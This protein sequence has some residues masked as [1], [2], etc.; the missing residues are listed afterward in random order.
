MANNSGMIMA[1]AG[2]T[3]LR[4]R[5]TAYRE[6]A[7]L[8]MLEL[9]READASFANLECCLQEGEDWPAYVAGTGRGATYMAANRSMVDDLKWMG[10]KMVYAANNHSADFDPGGVLTT[11]KYLMAGELPYAGLGASLTEATAPG[12]LETAHG[13]VA[14]ISLSDWGPRG[15]MDLSFQM[16]SHMMP[17][18]Q[19]PEFKSRPGVNLLRY[20][21]VITVDSATMDALRRASKELR[22]E[23]AKASRRSGIGKAVAFVG[24]TLL[25][26]EQDTDIVFHFMGKKFVLGDHFDISTEP[27]QEDL[28]RNYRWI[29][30][31]RRQA[32]FVVVAL[33][34]QGVR[35]V[36]DEEYTKIFAK[37]SIDA[38]A[39]VYLN[40]GAR[41]G[42]VE[43]Y[44]GKT[45]LYGV[46]NFY[47]QQDQVTAVPH[48][49]LLRWGMSTDTTAGEFLAKREMGEGKAGR[50]SAIHQVVYDENRE[51][52]EVRIYPLEYI[53][54]SRSQ[55]RRPMLAK[56]GSKI[57]D[58]VLKEA[59]ER[60]KPY[61]T[62][63]EIRDG[64][65]IARPK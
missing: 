34:D 6:E 60:S 38:G 12:Y 36:F 2:N 7:F 8:R 52:K 51:V 25:G 17:A 22:W 57:S 24:P 19:G 20:D 49:M 64:V 62:D 48:E 10:I 56:P 50:H 53:D 65:G 29:R 46:P 37:G 32:D 26:G 61:G 1:F 14:L 4:H 9:L 18:D 16:P 43:F 59:I 33:H 28:E 41:H 47:L 42:G 11:I 58:L 39:D 63:V 30:E 21:S 55:L 45:I 40:N 27:Y 5:V 23:E 54:G 31:A 44:A 13:R 3:Y 35:R 15:M